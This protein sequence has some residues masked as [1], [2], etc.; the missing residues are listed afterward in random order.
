MGKT[1][2]FNCLFSCWRPQGDPL[3]G[4]VQKLSLPVRTVILNLQHLR[5]IS[6]GDGHLAQDRLGPRCPPSDL[7][8]RAV[9]LLWLPNW[10]RCQLDSNYLDHPSWGRVKGTSQQQGQQE[11]EEVGKGGER[12]ILFWPGNRSLTKIG[13]WADVKIL[14]I[15][16]AMLGIFVEQNLNLHSNP[17]KCVTVW[18]LFYRGRNWSTERASDLLET[19]KLGSVW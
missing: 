17:M 18:A 9:P 12:G 6:S 10:R 14:M 19:T 16:D 7:K 1:L 5:Q 4:Q 8:P 11:E 15:T 13:G 2:G 3:S